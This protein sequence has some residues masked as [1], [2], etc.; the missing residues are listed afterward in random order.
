[1]KTL[2]CM[3]KR[4]WMDIKNPLKFIG[5]F[6]AWVFFSYKMGYLLAHK[7]HIDGING[8]IL[9][10]SAIIFFSPIFLFM[11]YI[12]IFSVYDW[13]IDIVKYFKRIYKECCH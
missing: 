5:G 4:I 13:A 1:V 10:F 8:D 2:I 12:I 11:I 6:C 7:Y 9:G 3:S